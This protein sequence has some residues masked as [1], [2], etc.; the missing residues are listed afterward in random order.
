M[1]AAGS[2]SITGRSNSSTSLLPRFVDDDDE[3][4]GLDQILAKV[5]YQGTYEDLGNNND[6][7]NYCNK[8]DREKEEYN[9]DENTRLKH[10]KTA[11]NHGI[12]Y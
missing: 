1:S 3:D 4:E 12:T 10:N 11:Y 5:Y 6:N 7:G 8:D 2:R 9:V